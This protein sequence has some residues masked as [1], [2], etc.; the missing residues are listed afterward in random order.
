[1]PAALHM[2]KQMLQKKTQ[3]KYG[4]DI[5]KLFHLEHEWKTYSKFSYS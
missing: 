1:M 4:A 3:C 5:V 2:L